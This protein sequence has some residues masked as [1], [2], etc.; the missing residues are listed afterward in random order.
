MGRHSFRSR[1]AVSAMAASFSIFSVNITTYLITYH[2]ALLIW[3]QM[4]SKF[5]QDLFPKWWTLFY[6]VDAMGLPLSSPYLDSVGAP[7]FQTGCNF[8]TGGSTILPVNANAISPFSFGIQVSQFIRF[9]ARVLE[10]LSKGTT[11]MFMSWIYFFTNISGIINLS[12][13]TPDRDLQKFLPSEDS[14]GQGLYMFDI[15]QNDIDGAFASKS[16][17]HQAFAIIP[18]MLTEFHKGI[19]VVNQAFFKWFLS[20]PVL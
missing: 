20:G 16:H 19:K 9:K 17:H 13:C 6:T 14:F 2:I 12:N 1:L 11:F 15:G 7:N 10:L 18:A 8:A 4:C 5:F 3:E